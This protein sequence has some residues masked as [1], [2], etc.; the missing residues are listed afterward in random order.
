MEQFSIVSGQLMTYVPTIENTP[1]EKRV[2]AVYTFQ[3]KLHRELKRTCPKYLVDNA[4]KV[5]HRVIDLED[6][7]TRPEIDSLTNLCGDLSKSKSI[8]VYI[9]TIDD[10]FPDTDITDFSNR[11]REHWGQRGSFEKGNV[12]I[13]ISK[14][15]RQIRISTS[16]ISMK[17]LTDEKCSDINKVIIPHFKEGKYFNGLVSGLNEIKKSL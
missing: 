13:A 15:L 14:S 7:F 5:L 17:F 11:N 9:V 12:M 2:K 3:Y 1:K 8:F 4:P 10:Y 16:D 6:I